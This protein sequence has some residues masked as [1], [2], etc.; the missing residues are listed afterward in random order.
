MR[1]MGFPKARFA[2]GKREVRSNDAAK[3]S[4]RLDVS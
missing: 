1:F 2:F 3:L 4:R